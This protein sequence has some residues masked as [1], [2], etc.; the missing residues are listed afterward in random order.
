MRL[1]KSER[2]LFFLILGTFTGLERVQM[3]SCSASTVDSTCCKMILL[4]QFSN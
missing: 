4:I 3:L 2:I 1:A